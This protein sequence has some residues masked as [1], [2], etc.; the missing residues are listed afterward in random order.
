MKL[1][2]TK[3]HAL[4]DYLCGPLLI[5][6]PWI[7]NFYDKSAQT[8]LPI[9]I[10]TLLIIYSLFTKYESSLFKALDLKA[11]LIIDLMLGTL[12]AISPWL[13]RFNEIVYG[14]HLILGLIMISVS[15]LSESVV[16]EKHIHRMPRHPKTHDHLH[17]TAWMGHVE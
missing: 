5:A 14:P 10:G 8:L 17:S 13:F 1:I 11:H 16:G 12:L 2:N 6:S 9:S 15:F 7:F 3:L 4:S